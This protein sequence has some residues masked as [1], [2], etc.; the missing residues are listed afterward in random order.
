[1]WVHGA[2][3]WGPVLPRS[4]SHF[5]NPNPPSFPPFPRLSSLTDGSC[6][7]LKQRHKHRHGP[8]RLSWAMS[9]S[10]S[11]C[12]WWA[13]NGT[14]LGGL[15]ALPLTCPH[16]IQRYWYLHAEILKVLV[17]QWPWLKLNVCLFHELYHAQMPFSKCRI[18]QIDRLREQDSRSVSC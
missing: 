15:T 16:H 10:Q 12:W 7:P 13:L 17:L 6:C 11:L 14:G 9:S 4:R 2:D 18:Y 8:G 5:L 1:M 3:S